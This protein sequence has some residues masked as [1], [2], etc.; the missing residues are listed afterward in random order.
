V[1]TFYQKIVIAAVIAAFAGDPIIF[2]LRKT[3]VNPHV[4]FD[5][6]IS[7]MLER[8]A[9]IL[10]IVLGG[11]YIVLIPFIVLLRALS[12]LGEGTFRKFSNIIK[13]EE[14]A[15]QFQKIRLKSELAVTL[16]ASPTIGILLGIIATLL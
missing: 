5:I 14:P 6:D 8:A 10:V 13:R 15:I 9:L 16:L 2:Y 4:R 7:G 1:L 3:L 12:L 11:N